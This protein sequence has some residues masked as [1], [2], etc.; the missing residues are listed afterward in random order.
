[1]GTEP[2]A[3]ETT[4]PIAGPEPVTRPPYIVAADVKGAFDSIP[5]A[6]LERVACELVGSGEYS[7]SRLA[8]VVGGAAV[9]VRTKTQRIATPVAKPGA[10]TLDEPGNERS[11][12]RKGSKRERKVG[13]VVIDLANPIAVH[14]NQVLELLRE[15]LRRNVVRSG[16]CIYSR[17]R[18]YPREAC[19]PRCC[20]Q[21]FTRTWN[22]PTA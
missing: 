21:C 14:K 6:A 12:P 9:G 19:C 11:K 2:N 18:E 16:G 17:P 1:M 22:R 5:L 8:R 20:V 7:V 15:H 3:R 10:P 13:G 4:L